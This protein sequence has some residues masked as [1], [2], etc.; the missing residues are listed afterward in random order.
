MTE[1]V[2]AWYI[3]SIFEVLPRILIPGLILSAGALCLNLFDRRTWYFALGRALPRHLFH[4]PAH[5]HAGIRFIPVIQIFLS[6]FGATLPLVFLKEIKFKPALA[7]IALL[8]VVLWT[9]GNVATSKAGSPGTTPV[10]KAKT[11]WPLFRQIN[12]HL[13]QTD[14]GRVVYEH[15]PLH[16]AFGT[17]RAFESLP[18]FAK[19]NTLEGLYMQSS[20]SSPFVFYPVGDLQGLLRPFSAV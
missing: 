14:G 15:S 2:T 6:I 20:P 1:Y 17:E 13:R 12:D 18:L 7:A 19:R 4:Q 5:R 16:N 10:S 3:K 11:P 8:T 9:A